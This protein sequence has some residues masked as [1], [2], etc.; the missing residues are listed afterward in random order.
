MEFCQK[1]ISEG[2][3]LKWS[4]PSGTR[5]EA[6]DKETLEYLRQTGCNYLCYAPESGSPDTLKLIKKAVKLPR[7]TESIIEA[8][9]LGLVLRTN[10]VVGFPG[11]TRHDVFLTFKYGL[12]MAIRGVDEVSL[13][14]FSPYPGSEIFNDLVQAGRVELDD[15]YLLRLTS[16][17]TDYT[18]LDLMGFNAE[19]SARELALWRAAFMVTGYLIG[20]VLYPSRILRTV[21]NV[22][23]GSHEAATVF[24][25]RFKDT[26][27]RFKVLAREAMRM[28]SLRRAGPPP[29]EQ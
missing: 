10:L 21:R 17:Y 7:I 5:S 2:I 15:S 18:N 4:L 23:F 11:E 28:N 6:L 25:H 1:L 19:M 13:N 24:E 8:K 29:V 9:K 26:L 20:Y 12:M 27:S 14:V 16:N 3:H 22:F